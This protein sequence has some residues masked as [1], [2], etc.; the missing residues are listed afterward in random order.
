MRSLH[1]PHIPTLFKCHPGSPQL[2]VAARPLQYA[3][4][5]GRSGISES[6]AARGRARAGVPN[7]GNKA[8]G[9]PNTGNK[10]KGVPNTGNAARGV[11]KT[12]NRAKGVP[13]LQE[14]KEDLFRRIRE[15][16]R[17]E[18]KEDMFRRIRELKY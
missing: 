11:P 7:T 14:T 13:R 3:A 15:L 10:A 17:G 16:N 4:T 9:V 18:T 8:K 1:I 2:A 5:G 12:G 6:C